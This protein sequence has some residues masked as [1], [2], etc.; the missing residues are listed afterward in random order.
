MISPLA[1]RLQ[2]FDLDDTL[3]NTRQAY[4]RAQEDIVRQSFSDL[5]GVRLASY[6]RRL[7]WFC[8]C[9][10]SGNVRQYLIAF[11]ADCGR[12]MPAADGIL[13]AMLTTYRQ[14][15]W[16][17]L[18]VFEGAIA[19]LQRANAAGHV[20]ALVSNGD[21]GSQEDKLNRTG[22]GAIFPPGTQ[23]ISG[24]FPEACRKP[25]P[26]LVEQACLAAGVDPS[27]AVF[28][29]NTTTDI[30]AGNLAGVTTV[31][32]GPAQD[33]ISDLPSLALPDYLLN[34]WQATIQPFAGS[35]NP[36]R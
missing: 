26:Y 7:A 14:S 20:M 30:L 19:F 28:Y 13:D 5:D 18:T 16:A 6:L 35:A 33:L 2:I 22:L 4:H 11:L 23:F 24:S 21:T 31:Q 1:C 25:S 36:S 34:D 15:Y 9:F 29:G 3:I 17:Y 32:F 8:R 10:G 12:S 27:Q